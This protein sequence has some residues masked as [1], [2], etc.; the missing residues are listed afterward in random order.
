[1]VIL[2]EEKLEM[3]IPTWFVQ[4][5]EALTKRYRQDLSNRYE[6]LFIC[7][8]ANENIF[9]ASLHK[10]GIS[11]MAQEDDEQHDNNDDGNR[12]TDENPESPPIIALETTSTQGEI[13]GAP[14]Q[15]TQWNS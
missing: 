4:H 12:K 7:C 2:K 9:A 14:Q 15:N 1:M 3:P 11:G 6:P 10:S 5:V 13:S 8:F